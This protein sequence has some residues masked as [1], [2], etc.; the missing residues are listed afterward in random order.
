[1]AYLHVIIP[2]GGG[3]QDPQPETRLKYVLSH[4]VINPKI[5]D[6][7][8]KREALDAMISDYSLNHCT[9]PPPII[10]TSGR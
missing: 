1:M 9:E 7:A 6:L 5:R 3:L 10:T 2:G 4:E 8:L